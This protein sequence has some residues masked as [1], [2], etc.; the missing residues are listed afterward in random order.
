MIAPFLALDYFGHDRQADQPH[1]YSADHVP[2]RERLT[3]QKYLPY[4]FLA[5]IFMTNE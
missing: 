1:G 5:H 3:F 2:S 4:V